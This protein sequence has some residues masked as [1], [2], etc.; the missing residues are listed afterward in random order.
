MFGVFS[1][2]VAR[3]WAG[4]AGGTNNMVPAAMCSGSAIRTWV[5][6][7]SRGSVITPVN[8]DAAAVSGLHR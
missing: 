2:R 4:S 5:R 7:R 1:S 8:A 6:P 3:A